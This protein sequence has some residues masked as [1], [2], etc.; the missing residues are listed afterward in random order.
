MDLSAFLIVVGT[1]VLILMITGLA[2]SFT[3]ALKICCRFGGGVSIE[4]MEECVVSVKVVMLSAFLAG[5]TLFI[6]SV[7]GPLVNVMPNGTG[8]SHVGI[9]VS[10]LGSLYG[11]VICIIMLPVLGRLYKVKCGMEKKNN[12]RN[13]TQKQLL[14]E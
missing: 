2:K 12:I 1:T 9:A 6:A 11:A 5:L 14:L 3:R 4:E 13:N 8:V 10:L 7:I